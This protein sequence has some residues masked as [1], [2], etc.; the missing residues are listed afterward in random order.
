MNGAEV[1]LHSL[2]TSA[3]NG[4]GWSNSRPG[5]FITGKGPRYKFNRILDGLQGRYG[6]FG[7]EADPFPLPE[8]ELLFLTLTVHHN[9]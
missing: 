1:Q 5:H 3:L 6:C 4:N 2:L 7:E 8:T 9:Q